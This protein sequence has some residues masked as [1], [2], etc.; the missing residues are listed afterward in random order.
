[1]LDKKNARIAMVHNVEVRR[2]LTAAEIIE[3]D[4]V[5]IIEF[6]QCYIN[7]EEGELIAKASTAIYCIEEEQ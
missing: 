6:D 3:L 1:M 4:A 7:F 5:G 2:K